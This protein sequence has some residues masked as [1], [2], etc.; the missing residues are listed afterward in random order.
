MSDIQ[1][2]NTLEI[3]KGVAGL[4]VYLD[5]YRIAGASDNGSMS[6]VHSWKINPV[7]LRSALAQARGTP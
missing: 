5:G 3:F 7:H 4:A 6:L 1:Q 2:R